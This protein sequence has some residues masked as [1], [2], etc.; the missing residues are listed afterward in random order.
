MSTLMYEYLKV[1]DSRLGFVRDTN[2]NLN[3]KTGSLK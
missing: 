2:A 3:F 1:A